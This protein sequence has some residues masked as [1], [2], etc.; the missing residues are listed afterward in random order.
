MSIAVSQKVQ[1]LVTGQLQNMMQLELRAEAQTRSQ[2]AQQKQAEEAATRE[3]TLLKKQVTELEERRNSLD[4]GFAAGQY[5][6]LRTKLQE[7]LEEPYSQSTGTLVELLRPK[8]TDTRI[9]DLVAA[10]MKGNNIPW[11]FRL[12]LN[13]ELYRLTTEERFLEGMSTLLK[14]N[15][16]ALDGSLSRLFSPSSNARWGKTAEA[17]VVR[18][19]ISWGLDESVGK[20]AR[21]ALLTAVPYGNALATYSESLSKDERDRGART[22]GR[23]MLSLFE[24]DYCEPLFTILRTFSETAA[25]VY[26]YL[27]L[28]DSSRPNVHG[29]IV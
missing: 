9:R 3:I 18:L 23:L 2:A 29:C 19:A 15:R 17:S 13:I 22:F 6:E 14:S 11:R 12:L 1:Q 25:R 26:S 21:L 7:D 20:S 28:Q 5:Q 24:S 10:D 27:I 16:L 4:A 8:L